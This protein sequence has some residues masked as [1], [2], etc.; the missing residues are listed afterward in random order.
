MKNKCNCHLHEN[1]VCDICQNIDP[2]N[3]PKDKKHTDVKSLMEDI[4]N[5]KY[6]WYTELEWWINRTFIS[7]VRNLYDNTKW[8]IQRGRRGYSDCDVWGLCHYLPGVISQSVNHLEKNLHSFPMGMTFKQ[9]QI[10]LRK[11]VKSFEIMQKTIDGN[12]LFLPTTKWTEK[13]YEE[14]KDLAKRM[15]R[16]NKAMNSEG[17]YKVMT[18]K[19]VLKYEEGLQL[20]IENLGGLWD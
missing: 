15:N 6:P 8:F 14:L 10:I 18:K 16:A 2:K 9:W 4:K 13:N 12:L 11:I 17:K 19:Q 5:T 3:P 7:P 20:F 1:L